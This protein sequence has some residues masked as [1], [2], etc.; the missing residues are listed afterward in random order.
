[1]NKSIYWIFSI[2]PDT[3]VL[4]LIIELV[5]ATNM[6]VRFLTV[7]DYYSFSWELCYIFILFSLLYVGIIYFLT[8]LISNYLTFLFFFFYLNGFCFYFVIYSHYKEINLPDALQYFYF[9][10]TFYLFNIDPK[11]ETYLMYL[12]YQLLGWYLLLCLQII[13]QS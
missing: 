4:F 1:M 8:N 7:F 3:I 10:E 6:L 12:I 11:N 5:Y 13:I 2:I 9:S